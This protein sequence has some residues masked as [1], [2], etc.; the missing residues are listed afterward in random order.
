MMRFVLLGVVASLA[1]LASG[2]CP[3]EAPAETPDP[4]KMTPRASAPEAADVGETVGL[5]ARL[6]D[7]VDPAS[8]S[9]VWFQTF[10][11]E[12]ELLG[13]D[14]ADASFVAPSL[15]VD[16]TLSFRVDVITSDGT[17]YSD[18]VTVTVAA[19]PDHGLDD[20]VVDDKSGEDDP[21]P[22]V[23]LV[24]NMGTI[25]VTLNREAA[26]LTVN[27]FLRYVDDGFYD[28]TIFHRVI[29]DFVVQGGGFD[30]ELEE[31]ETRSPIRNEADNGLKNHR[32]TIAMARTTEYD[33]ATSQFYINLVDNDSLDYTTAGTGY[34]VFGRV[35]AG[36]DMV[37]EIAA[38]ETGTQ[39]GMSDVPVTNVVLQRVDRVV[40]LSVDS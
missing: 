17:I 26:P 1:L 2:G 14:T 29:A 11:R 7:D 24:T 40:G 21:F 20:S 6:D 34:A 32:A 23:R 5:T 27:N 10:G 33:S 30:E 39:N 19:D 16:Q 8:V 15:G 35:T 38:V 22:Q 31:K 28:G 3:A 4:E 12:V 25:T 18:T 36:M 13:A 9:Y 37:D